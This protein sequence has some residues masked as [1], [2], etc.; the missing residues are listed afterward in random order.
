MLEG[1]SKSRYKLTDRFTCEGRG[2]K[3]YKCG[4]IQTKYDIRISYT[5]H[6]QHKFIRSYFNLLYYYI[7]PLLINHGNEALSF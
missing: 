1:F 6:T 7:F 3:A 2:V 5:K 4:A